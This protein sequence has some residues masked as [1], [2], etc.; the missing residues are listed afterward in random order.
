MIRLTLELKKLGLSQSEC[1][2]RACVN[3]TS[4]SRIITGK[5]PAFPNRGKR[6]ADAIGWEGDPRELFEEV[7][8]DDLANR[9]C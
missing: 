5:E 3:Q 4:L 2:R 9:T 6:I 8:R 1:A 7:G